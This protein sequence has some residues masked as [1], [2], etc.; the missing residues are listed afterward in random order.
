[1]AIVLALSVFFFYFIY[2]I[3]FWAKALVY[4]EDVSHADLK[5]KKKNILNIKNLCIF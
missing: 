2:F 4:L 3:Y 5:K 1:M